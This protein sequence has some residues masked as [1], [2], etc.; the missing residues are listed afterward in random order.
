MLVG[1]YQDAYAPFESARIQQCK[2]A[3]NDPV[4][5]ENL[6]YFIEIFIRKGATYQR[7]L[8]NLLGNLKTDRV[9]RIGVNF[10]INKK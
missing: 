1:S 8:E 2:K 6:F 7:M 3:I 9:H 5:I 10:N 4:L